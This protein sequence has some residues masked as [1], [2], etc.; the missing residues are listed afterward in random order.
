M[1]EEYDFGEDSTMMKMEEDFEANSDDPMTA[2]G[3][4][5][6]MGDDTEGSKIDASKNEEDEGCGSKDRPVYQLKLVSIVII[7]INN[8]P[9]G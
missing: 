9:L 6:L 1:A 8:Q 3:D 2:V 7:F 5:G 4:P